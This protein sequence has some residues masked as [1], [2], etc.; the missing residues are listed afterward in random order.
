MRYIFIDA[1]YFIFFRFHALKNWWSLAKRDEPVIPNQ[2][3]EFKEKFRKTFV[4][5]IKEIAKKVGIPKGTPYRILVGKDCPRSDIWRT[6]LY[7]QYKEGRTDSTME[8]HFFSLTYEE[9]LFEEVCGESCI[10]EHPSLEADDVIALSVRHILEKDSEAL[11]YVITSDMDYLQLVTSERIKLYDL[12]YKL[13][14]E[15]SKY[16]QETN[17]PAKDL[18][19]KCL[20]GD[21][22]DNI[23]A[24][25]P[26]C[27][28]KTA[29]K[30]YQLPEEERNAI[31][32]S[33][34][35]W[36]QYKHN[37]SLIDFNFIPSTLKDEFLTRFESINF[38]I[39]G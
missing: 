15:K 30:L 7:E 10:L 23:P 12:K 38:N 31:I 4:E 16:F 32:K 19:V 27:G 37:Q 1:S 39:S 36:D 5:K 28:K 24:A 21:K 14:T 13:L 2:S 18:F 6:P 29:E 8:G 17:S 33:K 20:C 9:H 35:G 26:K 34:N 22:S 25:F 3:D 11:C